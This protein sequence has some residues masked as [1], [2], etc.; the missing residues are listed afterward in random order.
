MQKRD[1]FINF[2]K[3]DADNNKWGTRN[4]CIRFSECKS[5]GHVIRG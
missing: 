1:I 4:D 3:K 2:L 5:P